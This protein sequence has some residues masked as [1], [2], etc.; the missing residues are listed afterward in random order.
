M[1]IV[2]SLKSEGAC[3]LSG[4]NVLV[5]LEEDGSEATGPMGAALLSRGGD[6]FVPLELGLTRIALG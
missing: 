4:V 2:Y 5:K 6:I 3:S 1:R